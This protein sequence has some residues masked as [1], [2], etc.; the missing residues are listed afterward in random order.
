M[1]PHASKLI[2]VVEQNAKAIA[3][4]WYKNIKINPQDA[5]ISHDVGR[6]GHRAGAELL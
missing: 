6:K 2:E 1:R 3:Q 4:Q 5:G